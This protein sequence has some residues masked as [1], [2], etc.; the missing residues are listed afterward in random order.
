ML[1]SVC[2]D[3]LPIAGSHLSENTL[4]WGFKILVSMKLKKSSF[5]TLRHSISL[6][7]NLPPFGGCIWTSSKSLKG[8]S[9]VY[10]FGWFRKWLKQHPVDDSL[11][12]YSLRLFWRILRDR[13]HRPPEF[14]IRKLKC[15]SGQRNF[16]SEG[17]DLFLKGLKIRLNRIFSHF[18]PVLKYF[19]VQHGIQFV[20]NTLINYIWYMSHFLYFAHDLLQDCVGKRAGFA[21]ATFLS[22]RKK[23][24]K[25]SRSTNKRVHLQLSIIPTPLSRGNPFCWTA[26]APCYWDTASDG[27]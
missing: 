2:F 23:E 10:T 9:S 12:K 25:P 6:S 14:I 19:T 26:L 7:L 13:V 4:L 5:L 15:I 20:F 16:F 8:W 17:I 11:I 18:G 27:L 21:F 22:K 24:K 3:S 1:K